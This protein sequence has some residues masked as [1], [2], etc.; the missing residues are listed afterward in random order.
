MKERARDPHDRTDAAVPT[1]DIQ[2]DLDAEDVQHDLEAH[3]SS[4]RELDQVRTRSKALRDD[5]ASMLNEWLASENYKKCAL[6]ERAMAARVA[7]Q[8]SRAPS[9]LHR[10]DLVADDTTLDA[11]SA[12]ACPT[13]FATEAMRALVCTPRLTLSKPVMLC[14]YWVVRELFSTAPPEWRIGGAR[15]GN[16]GWATA[17]ATYQCMSAILGLAAALDGAAA[18]FREVE[19][20]EGRLKELGNEAIPEEWRELET[21]RLAVSGSMSLSLLAKRMAIDV[22]VP[23]SSDPQTF[24]DFLQEDKQLKA[25]VMRA[26]GEAQKAIGS[27]LRSTQAFRNKEKRQAR[28]AQ[29]GQSTQARHSTDGHDLAYRALED[30]RDRAR[31][32]KAAAKERNWREL[33]HQF[34][35]AGQNVRTVLEPN[36]SFLSSVIDRQL[37]ASES[38]DGS[39]WDLPELVFATL[40]YYRLGSL[41]GAEIERMKD[42]T[43]RVCENLGADGT[44][45]SGRPYHSTSDGGFLVSNTTVLAAIAELIRVIRHPISERLSRKFLPYLEERKFGRRSSDNGLRGF[46]GEF[47]RIRR[48]TDLSETAQAVDALDTISDALDET[49]N[50]TILDHFNVRT[51]KSAPTLDTLFYA[52]YGFA[53]K[54]ATRE[55][56]RDSIA[57]TL[58]RMR[59]H[60]EETPGKHL[61]SLVL[62]GPPGTGKTTLVEALANTCGVRL[63]EVTPSDL[64]KMG[65]PA[66]ERRAR[67]VFYALSLLTRVVVL[68]DEFD[69]VLRDREQAGK[70]ALNILSFLTPGMLP[71]LKELSERASKQSSAYVL[72]T[73]L[74]G[75]LDDAAVR[76][77]RFDERVGIFP[78]DPLSRLG[79]FQFLCGTGKRPKPERVA[80]FVFRSGGMGMTPLM[81][82]GWYRLAG[83]DL[84]DTP[85]GYVF[86]HRSDLNGLA[87]EPEARFEER[88]IGDG[89][90]ALREYLQWGWLNEW[91]K[92]LGRQAAPGN[93]KKVRET[94]LA[95]PS[96]SCSQE[97]VARMQN[98]LKK[99]DN[100]LLIA[101]LG[102]EILLRWKHKSDGLF[103]KISKSLERPRTPDQ[104][105]RDCQVPL[106]SA[107]DLYVF[108][109][110]AAHALLNPVFEDDSVASQVVYV[111]V[112]VKDFIKQQSVVAAAAVGRKDA[113][114]VRRW[115]ELK[116]AARKIDDGISKLFVHIDTQYRAYLESTSFWKDKPPADM[117]QVIDRALQ[118]RSN[119][120]H[121]A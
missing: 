67:A 88:V 54:E 57:M 59:A 53:V 90:N 75:T 18:F 48:H 56:R 23:T 25:A 121:W 61:H 55:V 112:L 95:W 66:I 30:A 11:I 37:A 72:I 78:P 39:Q 6:T 81:A 58:Q 68:F 109:R 92:A 79:Y 46:Y 29:R 91:E 17:Y 107:E 83:S 97:C 32:V 15:A 65:E 73:N 28:L 93:W 115:N 63:V 117:K 98:L 69:P 19:K 82:K 84:G 94:V 110:C 64:A 74:I 80:E 51:P 40:S 102:D 71:K 87:F 119:G 3:L 34:E 103:A 70:G 52:D 1:S 14:W 101:L 22:A 99:G 9:A 35:I 106:L 21:R 96:Q 16:G 60:V 5:G 44:V 86:G 10:L 36:R 118:V 38:R 33:A 89:P 111:S 76:Q 45:P 24:S 114:M 120:Q 104:I 12:S 26:I 85:M 105:R 100:R 41:D 47:D 116:S 50:D 108:E 113:L 8:M 4:L 42:A 2:S 43:E 13:V 20:L 31:T 77:G 27:A 7:W 62:Y 49:I